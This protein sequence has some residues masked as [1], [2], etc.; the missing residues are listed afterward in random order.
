MEPLFFQRF[1]RSC[2]AQGRVDLPSL[3][4]LALSSPSRGGKNQITKGAVDVR[5]G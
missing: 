3:S 2:D 4:S 1:V 5:T